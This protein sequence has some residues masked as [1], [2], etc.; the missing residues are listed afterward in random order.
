M[1]TSSKTLTTLL[2]TRCPYLPV[3]WRSPTGNFQ[4]TFSVLEEKEEKEKRE[5]YKVA[6]WRT[7][8]SEAAVRVSTSFVKL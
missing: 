2:P 3:D 4:I 8:N 5:Y 6:G 1:Y 7:R